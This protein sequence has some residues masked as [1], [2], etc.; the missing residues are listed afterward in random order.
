M[1]VVT[2]TH[3]GRSFRLRCDP[4]SIAW[5]YTLNT[6]ID[7]TYGGRVVQI[8]SVRLGDL[9][10][11]SRMGRGRWE[12]L[13][14]LIMFCRDVM[15]QQKDTGEP[16]LL[17]YPTK[18]WAVKV[19]LSNVPFADQATN[20]SYPYSLRFKVQEDV[21]GVLSADSM[22]SELNRIRDGIG[23]ERNDYNYPMDTV[24]TPG[25]TATTAT[26]EEVSINAPNRGSM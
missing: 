1:G 20:V 26:G 17:S 21:N 9:T 11:Q 22:T 6:K 2:L 24:E 18:G 19:F 12:A 15:F 10:I 16:A 4:H 14:E 13:N 8:L 3:G 5:S 23:Y 7:E 25:T